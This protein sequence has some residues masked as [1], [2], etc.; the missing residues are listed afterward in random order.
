MYTIEVIIILCTVF[1]LF[2]FFLNA[3]L[4]V[5]LFWH[6]MCVHMNKYLLLYTFL[7]RCVC[8]CVCDKFKSILIYLCDKSFSLV[9][10]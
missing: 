7:S 8:V 2:S 10:M 1:L 3:S 6:F 5:R 9:E 4:C